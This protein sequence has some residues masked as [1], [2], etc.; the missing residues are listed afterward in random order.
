[1]VEQKIVNNNIDIRVTAKKSKDKSIRFIPIH[2]M[3]KKKYTQVVFFDFEMNCKLN[4][5]KDS[6]NEIISLGAA[7]YNKQKGVEKERIFYSLVRPTKNSLLSCKCRELTGIAQK[8]I[9]CARG[10]NEVMKDFQ[11]WVGDIEKTLFV[12]WSDED[13]RAINRDYEINVGD[14]ELCDAINGSYAD[15]QL[16]FSKYLAAENRVSLKNAL[17]VYNIEFIGN[18][19]NAGYD[20]LNLALLYEAYDRKRKKLRSGR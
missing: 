1:M 16:E 7:R 3:I 14:R 11:N 9:D 5:I 18:Q 6:G 15:F 10:F 17:H 8:D 12:S 4:S 2:E 19:H 13:I 20:A